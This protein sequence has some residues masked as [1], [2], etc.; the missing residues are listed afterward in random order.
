MNKNIILATLA[1]LLAVSI[2]R[3]DLSIDW[4]NSDVA[5]SSDGTVDGIVTGNLVQL[6][7][8]AIG[9]TTNAGAYPVEGGATQAGEFVLASINADQ[10]GLWSIVNGTYTSADVSGADIHAGFFFTRIFETGG[11]EIGTHF[12]DVNVVDA[13]QW[14]YDPLDTASV[15]SQEAISANTSL[16]QGDILNVTAN[17]TTVI[18]EAGTFSLMTVSGLGLFMVRKLIRR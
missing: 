8:S 10:Y 6:L 16:N 3:A 2:S 12:Y 7:W 4:Y 18:P 5:V 14:I 9:N 11:A 17:G 15:Y 1:M 13:S